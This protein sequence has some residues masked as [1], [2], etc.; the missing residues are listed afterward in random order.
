V[1]KVGVESKVAVSE[2]GKWWS[3][4]VSNGISGSQSGC[5]I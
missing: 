3:R 5:G 1:V 4:L 2:I